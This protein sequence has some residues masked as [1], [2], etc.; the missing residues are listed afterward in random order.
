MTTFTHVGFTRAVGHV[1]AARLYG[2][3]DYRGRAHALNGVSQPYSGA[4]YAAV[5]G[6]RVTADHD[7]ES[8]N[9]WPAAD[10]VGVRCKRC[11][12]IIRARAEA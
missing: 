1:H 11:L 12:K 7:G 2:H 5:C 3:A 6:E 9:V 8:F 10:G 4:V